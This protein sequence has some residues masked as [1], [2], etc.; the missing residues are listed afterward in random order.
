MD[1]EID[2]SLRAARDGYCEL[3]RDTYGACIANEG[4]IL[5]DIPGETC[6]VELF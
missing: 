1:R 4:E 6:E 3:T 2:L 5:S